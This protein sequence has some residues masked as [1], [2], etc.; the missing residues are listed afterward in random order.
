MSTAVTFFNDSAG[1]GCADATGIE[2][3]MA[4]MALPLHGS[5]AETPPMVGMRED[6]STREAWRE[7]G[8]ENNTARGIV[9]A[10]TPDFGLAASAS[11]GSVLAGVPEGEGPSVAA[12]V[13]AEDV[14]HPSARPQGRASGSSGTGELAK[15]NAYSGGPDLDGQKSG[16]ATRLASQG[17]AG[18]ASARSRGTPVDGETLAGQAEAKPEKGSGK[19]DI[20]LAVRAPGVFKGKPVGTAP[21]EGRAVNGG[22]VGH[23]AGS[24]GADEGGKD[25]K[26]LGINVGLGSVGKIV[27][28]DLSSPQQTPNVAAISKSAAEV[29]LGA[30]GAASAAAKTPVQSIGEQM[31]N[32]IHAT[33]A[34]GEQR[35]VVRLE[36]PELGTVIV[37]F[38]QRGDE[39]QGTLDVGR[40]DTRHQIEQALPQV[41]RG[42]EEAGVNVR[43]L[44]VGLADQA[45]R[46]PSRGQ[47]AQGDVP[48]HQDAE[49]SSGHAPQPANRQRSGEDGAIDSGYSFETCEVATR[50]GEERI[51]ML[52]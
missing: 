11:S 46:D 21:T 17:A 31:M 48:Q 22:S 13:P 51:D 18:H 39:L 2:S 19:S 12:E 6:A 37:R 42:L 40:T 10:E 30:H 38:Q 15:G 35:V 49:Q 26:V 7:D 50:P 5:F 43:R 36:P 52:V 34:R 1:L 25:A 45:G 33:L 20:M 32:S 27:S 8:S 44:D 29:S 4:S 3:L 41:L 24:P 16:E 23:V 14:P 28:G 47:L 9:T